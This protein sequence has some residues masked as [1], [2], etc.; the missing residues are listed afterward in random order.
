MATVAPVRAVVVRSVTPLALEVRPR[1]TE[2]A[3]EPAVAAV[4][5]TLPDWPARSLVG[6][7]RASVP[8]AVEAAM[9]RLSW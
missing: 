4:T 7:E 3:S 5:T 6:A 8:T 2:P 1:A 9:S